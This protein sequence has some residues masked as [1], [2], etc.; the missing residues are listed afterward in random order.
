LQDKVYAIT[1]AEPF[2]VFQACVYTRSHANRRGSARTFLDLFAAL[3]RRS[4]DTQV[5]WPVG[6]DRFSV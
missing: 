4:F 5:L 6:R 1:R 3:P 2:S